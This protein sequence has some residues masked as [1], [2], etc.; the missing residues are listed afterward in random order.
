[1]TDDTFG[2]EP[3]SEESKRRLKAGQDL[4]QLIWDRIQE[5]VDDLGDHAAYAC[6]NNLIIMHIGYFNGR[7]PGSAH[8]LVPIILEQ[9]DEEPGDA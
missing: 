4:A 3:L 8:S 6:L 9:L 5:E 1:M 2:D 7:F